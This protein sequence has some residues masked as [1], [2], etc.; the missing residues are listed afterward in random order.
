MKEKMMNGFLVFATKLQSQRHVSA[1]KNGFTTLMPIIIVGSF[2]TLFSNIVCN[3]TPG[4]VSVANIPGMAWL[5]LT[6]AM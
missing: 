6:K 5:V 2:C 3:T 4:Y 1:I